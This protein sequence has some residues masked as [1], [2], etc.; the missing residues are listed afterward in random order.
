MLSLLTESPIVWVGIYPIIIFWYFG[1]G[2]PAGATGGVNSNTCQVF[3]VSNRTHDRSAYVLTTE[4]VAWWSKVKLIGWRTTAQGALICHGLT[5]IVARVGSSVPWK[6]AKIIIWYISG[7]L[8]VT[9]MCKILS[10]YLL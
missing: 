7:F 8:Y 5:M 3:L 9:I 2:L 6:Y 10:L 1:N 4:G